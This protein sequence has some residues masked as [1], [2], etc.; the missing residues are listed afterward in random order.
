MIVSYDHLKC[1][2]NNI[3]DICADNRYI[4]TFSTK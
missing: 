1:H 2:Y 4:K 3:P